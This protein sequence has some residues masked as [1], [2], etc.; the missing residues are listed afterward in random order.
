MLP[1]V[2]VCLVSAKL[3]SLRGTHLFWIIACWTRV[4]I[5][6]SRVKCLEWSV[7]RDSWFSRLYFKY[8]GVVLMNSINTFWL[9]N[10]FRLSLNLTYQLTFTT[11]LPR[12]P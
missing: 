7:V 3:G 12:Y 1:Q 11:I 6:N 10:S 5:S 8:F 9:S 2:T 4:V